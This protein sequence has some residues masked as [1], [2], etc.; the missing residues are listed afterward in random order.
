LI[1]EASSKVILKS[2][3]SPNTLKAIEQEIEKVKNEIDA[4]VHAPEFENAANLR[5]THTKLE[6]KYEEAKNEWKNAQNDMSN[7]F[8]EE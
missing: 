5:D 6:Q 7:S 8:T 1:D 4:A 3:T 2:H